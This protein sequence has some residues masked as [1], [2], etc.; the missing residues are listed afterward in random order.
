M[1]SVLVTQFLSNMPGLAWETKEKLL[2]IICDQ[3]FYYPDKNIPQS[4][5]DMA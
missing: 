3:Q 2:L 4:F 5:N 1:S